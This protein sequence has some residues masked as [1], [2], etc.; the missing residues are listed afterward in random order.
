[1]LMPKLYDYRLFISHAWKYGDSYKRLTYLLDKASN[2]EYYNFSAPKEKPLFPQGT[3]L[4]NKKIAEAI[5]NKI[6]PSQITIVISGMYVAYKDWIK[7]EINESVRMGK[8][9]LAIIPWGNKN[10]PKA[11]SDVVPIENI[12]GWNTNSIVSAIRRLVP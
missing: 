9:I 11:I 6:A 5:T 3:P 1:M 8:P 2:F 10:I 12:V 7:Y 4:T